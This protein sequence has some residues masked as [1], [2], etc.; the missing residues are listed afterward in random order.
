MPKFIKFEDDWTSS[1]NRIPDHCHDPIE[2]YLIHGYEPGGFLTAVLSNDLFTAVGR[3]DH[4][5]SASLSNI[6]LWIANNAPQ[7]SWGSYERVQAWCKDVDGRR[8]SFADP[9]KKAHMWEILSNRHE[10]THD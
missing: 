7:G 5:N 1:R 9:I 4:I 3:A 2:N 10:V 8:T 6:A